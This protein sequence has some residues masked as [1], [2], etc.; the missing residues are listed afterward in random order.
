MKLMRLAQI[1]TT[2]IKLREER[3]QSILAELDGI[4]ADNDGI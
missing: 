4:D 2:S 1:E 3:H